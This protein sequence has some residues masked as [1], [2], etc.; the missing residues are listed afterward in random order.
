MGAPMALRLQA[1]GQEVVAYNRSAD[2]L[3]PLI[4]Q[5]IAVKETP[6]EVIHASDCTILMLADA[7]AIAAT[8][9]S[10]DTVAALRD[11]TLIQ[12][13]T[14][15]PNQSRD[16]L[17]QVTEAGGQYLE[18]PVLGSIP[19]VK[20]GSLIVMVGSTPEQFE[21]WRSL[22]ACLGEQVMRI[23]TVGAGAGVKLAM[24]QLIGSLTHAFALSLAL[25]Q[26]EHIDV[27]VFMD[28]VR[29]SALYAPTFDKKLTR[30][31]DR[32]FDH[33]NFPTK[34]LLKDMRLFSQAATSA[35]LSPDLADCV[36]RMAEA[37]IAQGLGEQDYSALYAAVNPEE[38][39]SPR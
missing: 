4:Q 14:I 8:V 26:R 30:M 13:G 9:L 22:L 29:N 31:C 5:G 7:A 34:H 21:Q 25:V 27:D 20:D 3:K 10:S 16:L 2:K 23:G 19:Q 17:T 38:A 35:G 1:C 15:A 33:P 39:E 37:A 28:I 24:N 11:R 32:T 12:M 18:A 36:A 6:A